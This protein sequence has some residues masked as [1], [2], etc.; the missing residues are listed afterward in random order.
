MW[1]GKTLSDQRWDQR[2]WVRNLLR[3]S[4]RYLDDIDPDTQ[5]KVDAAREGGSPA[6]IAW[7]LARPGDS[8][9]PDLS[10][11]LLRAI[12][13]RIQHRAAIHAAKAAHGQG[14]VSATGPPDRQATSIHIG[15]TFGEEV[16]GE[17]S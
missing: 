17:R 10:R 14:D 2:I 3:N 6:P 11:R 5:A 8:D 1:T 16:S 4:L 15:Q 9:V 13:T 12:S 7:D